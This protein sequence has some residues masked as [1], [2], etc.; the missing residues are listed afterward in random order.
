MKDTVDSMEAE[1]DGLLAQVEKIN[2][3]SA[4][5]NEALGERRQKVR[6]LN[7]V[8]SVLQKV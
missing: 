3:K 8:H 5:L 2:T 4:V 7:G 1:M 6:Q